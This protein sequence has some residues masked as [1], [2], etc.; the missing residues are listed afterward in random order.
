[1]KTLLFPIVILLSLVS[2]AQNSIP[3]GDFEQWTTVS[4][5]NLDNYITESGRAQFLLGST[6]T[7][8]STDSQNGNSSVRLET[9]SNGHDTLF[10]FFTSG[11]FDHSNGFPYTQRP[12]SIIGYYKS[13]VLPGDTAILILRFSQLGNI[14][15][16][17]L[18]TFTGVQSTWSRFAFPLNLTQTPDS[19]F[20]AAA[21]S[22]AVSSIGVQVGSWLMLDNISFVGVGITQP[23]LN[24]DFENW[25]IES[26]D[27]PLNWSTANIQGSSIG[28]YSVT[29]T[30]DNT[31]GSYALRLETIKV[32]DDTIGFITNGSFGQDSILGGQPF[33]IVFDTLI[34][35]YK[36]S[37]VGPDS[38]AIGLNFFKNGNLIGVNYGFLPATSTYTQ[39]EVPFVLPQ[40]PDTLRIDVVSSINENFIGATLFLDQL[41][42][43]SI[44]TNINKSI[45]SFGEISLFPNPSNDLINLE[46]FNK[47]EAA[48]ITIIDN[49]GRIYHQEEVVK[50]RVNLQLNLNGLPVGSYFLRI[51]DSENI[52]YKKISK[53]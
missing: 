47:S 53:I 34:G 20:I 22:N 49:I 12:D 24:G 44:V 26:Y 10:G 41:L 38:A 21:S 45:D 17:Q 6:T 15:S 35:Q 37:P 11:D 40:V 42:L 36:Y 28:Q 25:T 43:K 46:F 48:N 19:M 7:I 1:M 32:F 3:N 51:S 4:F 9:K 39:F 5:N 52:T 16:F 2:I 27:N 33:G 13:N 8:K 50:G 31:E 30:P 14:Y 29:K 23:I 18:K